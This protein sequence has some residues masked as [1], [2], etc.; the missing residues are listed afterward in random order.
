MPDVTAAAKLPFQ[1]R[2]TQARTHCH[3]FADSGPTASILFIVRSGSLE[4]ILP[5][6][7]RFG[8]CRP[9][10]GWLWARENAACAC[11]AGRARFLNPR[12]AP[13]EPPACPAIPP[14]RH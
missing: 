11:Q 4:V 14:A 10:V 8:A 5:E 6:P 12:K 1:T 9:G 3:T 7:C 13:D 2:G